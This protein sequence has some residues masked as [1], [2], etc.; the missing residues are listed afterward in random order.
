MS[1]IQTRTAKSA[2]TKRSLTLLGVLAVL[3]TVALASL[4]LAKDGPPA[5]SRP[6]SPRLAPTITAGPSGAVS[7]T[8]ATFKF[9]SSEQGV[10]GYRCQLDHDQS[11]KCSS[12]IVYTHLSQ[13]SHT[14]KAMAVDAAGNVGPSATRTWSVDTIA[15]PTPTFSREPANPSFS[16][17]STFAW[18]SRPASDVDRY[19]CREEERAWFR[20]NSPLTF[21]VPAGGDGQHQFAVRAVDAAG[22]RSGQ[23]TYKW[24]LAAA[25]SGVPFTISGSLGGQLYPGAA[26]RRLPLTLTNPNGVA[27]YVTSLAVTVTSSPPGCPAAGNIALAQS[28][29]SSATPVQIPAKGSVTLPAQGVS[30]PTIALIDLPVNQDACKNTGFGLTYS[31]SAHS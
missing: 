31:G 30:A 22:N 21:T 27:I 29:A 26:P 10:A 17:I 24:K 25:Q 6:H 19:E 16:P 2:R 5:P 18:A 23:A 9:H 3:V 20:C 12:T 7:S 4:A 28:S 15:P 11:Q 1:P 13:G 14:F 8:T